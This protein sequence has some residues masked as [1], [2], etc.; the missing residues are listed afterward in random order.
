ML[1]SLCDIF[2]VSLFFSLE[3][4][5]AS[6]TLQSTTTQ[7]FDISDEYTVDVSI[8][9][10]AT[11]GV[12]YYLRGV[13]YKEGSTNYCGYTWNGAQWFNGPYSSDEG[14]KYFLPIT[15]Q[16]DQWSGQLKAKI[17]SSDSGCKESGTYHFKIQRFTASGGSSFD[18]QTAL[19]VAVVLPTPTPAPTAK[20]TLTVKPSP[21]ERPTA[22][23]KP[24]PTP[25]VILS[26]T[27]TQEENGDALTKKTLYQT[28]TST[29]I[30]K[31]QQA[32]VSSAFRMAKT[33]ESTPSSPSPTVAVLGVQESSTPKIFLGLGIL[34]LSI[35]GILAFRIYKREKTEV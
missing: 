22:T 34:F 7:L 9:I 25:K 35:C 16:N 15:I 18:T 24:S 28:V 10:S 2:Y 19:S 30:K 5:A 17:D 14:W 11:D 26:P 20:P 21:T 4:H 12:Q 6:L 27:P 3:A 33:V 8:T 32:T 1:T 31:Q 23:V 13:F 29:P